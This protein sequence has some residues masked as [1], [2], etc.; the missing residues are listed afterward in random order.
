MGDYQEEI[1]RHAC[2]KE[3]FIKST[4]FRNLKIQPIKFDEFTGHDFVA[5][6]SSLK[7]EN[8]EWWTYSLHRNH[9]SGLY[10]LHMNY[11]VEVKKGFRL[12]V[13]D[14]FRI[15]P[16]QK[17]DEAVE[18]HRTGGLRNPPNHISPTPPKKKRKTSQTT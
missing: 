3:A 7:R 16:K 6:L 18:Q 5:W 10:H 8:G 11:E 9:R 12:T 1:R 13:D 2:D 17:Y 4:I 15:L 14:F